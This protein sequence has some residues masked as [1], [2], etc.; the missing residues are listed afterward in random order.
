MNR[1]EAIF[2]IAAFASVSLLGCERNNPQPTAYVKRV[3]TPQGE[4]AV[5]S[6][7]EKIVEIN[8]ENPVITDEIAKR[9]EVDCRD[10]R[11]IETSDST[12]RRL[13]V[14]YTDCLRQRLRL[15]RALI[16]IKDNH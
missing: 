8:A 4:Q 12:K 13:S 11:T 5:V 3:V 7:T 15:D 10:V 9:V 16:S 6:Q 1:R 2:R 14:R